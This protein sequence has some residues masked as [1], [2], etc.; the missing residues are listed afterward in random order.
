MHVAKF[1]DALAF[2]PD[3]KIVEAALPDFSLEFRSREFRKKKALSVAVSQVM[4]GAG[5]G[6]RSVA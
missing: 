6:E 1:F 2:R 3:I 4:I 5:F